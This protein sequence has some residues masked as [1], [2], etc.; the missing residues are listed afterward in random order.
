M[1]LSITAISGASILTPTGFLENAV[2]TWDSGGAISRL[3]QQ[4]TRNALDGRG[5]LVCPGFINLHVHGGLG[6]DILDATPEAVATVARHQAMQGVTGF[7][8]TTA[9]ASQEQLVQVAH[10]ARTYQE[11]PQPG[12]AVLGLHIEGPYISAEK[13]GAQ[14]TAFFRDPAWEEVEEWQAAS[15][16]L[17][18]MISLAPERD[19]D[20]RFIR[21]AVASGIIV[22][23]AHTNASYQQAAAAIQSGLSHATHIFNAMSRF[24]YR[25]PRVLEALLAHPS[26]TVEVIPDCTEVPH[27]HPTAIRLLKRM[28]G[29]D[30]ICTITDAVSAAGMPDGAY[31]LGGLEVMKADK[32]VFLKAPWDEHG[33]RQLAGSALEMHQA[34]L[35]LAEQA[36]FSLDEALQTAALNPARVLGLDHRKGSLELGKDADLVVLDPQT[37]APRAT[38]VRGQLA[39][40]H[41]EAIP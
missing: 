8:P 37:L 18:R 13:S 15:G 39:W 36:G 35:N 32:M 7:L 34:V 12:A 19:P 17:V 2:I 6:A 38:F 4:P 21:R 14:N 9:S 29:V 26:I 11:D 3:N 33:E 1:K 20:G 22:S 10:A 16:G 23:A 31:S 25:S 40:G 28:A 5:L 27:V 24:D 30:R 41:L